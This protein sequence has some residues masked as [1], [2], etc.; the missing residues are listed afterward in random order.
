[1]SRLPPLAAVRTF[2]AAG[3]LQN[4][5]RA[6]E[7]LGLTQAAVSYQIRQLED[8]LGRALFVREKGRVRLSETGQRLLPA[9]SNAFATMG[10]AFAALGSDEAD[11]LT[12]NAA[13]SFGGTWLSARIGSFQLQYPELAVRMAMSNDLIDFDASN[14]DVAIRIGKGVWPGLR[15]DFLMRQ[16]LAPIASPA[17]IEEHDIR[18]P[19]DLLRVQRLAPNDSW[20]AEWFALAGVARPPASTRRGIEL[21][22]QLQ[23]GSAV[24]AGFGVAMMTPLYWQG[25]LASG[26][27]VQPFDTL[28]V[29]ASSGMWLVHRDNRVGVRKIERFR[30]WL[31]AEI[32]KDR[33]LLTDAL[34]EPPSPPELR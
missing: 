5:S 20:W 4:F 1:M 16:Y 7:E 32:E 11:V 12:I 15:S 28:Y 34:L 30:E 26:R 13:T 22:S 6:A 19:A 3:R 21:D 17:F 27:M 24:Q 9:I 14:V 31:H 8:R 23:E 33:H 18:E 25:E 10:D 29:S 2:E